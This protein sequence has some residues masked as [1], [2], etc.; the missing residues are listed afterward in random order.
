MTAQGLR[1]GLRYG[2]SGCHAPSCAEGGCLAAAH[3]RMAAEAPAGTWPC[4]V[5]PLPRHPRCCCS[6]GR[7]PG[8]QRH[9]AL[10]NTEWRRPQHLENASRVGMPGLLATQ[11]C[12][13]PDAPASSSAGRAPTLQDAFRRFAKEHKVR[14]GEQQT[15]PSL[16]VWVS[17]T[18]QPCTPAPP[19]TGVPRDVPALACG[20]VPTGHG[21][22]SCYAAAA[23]IQEFREPDS[24]LCCLATPLECILPLAS[25]RASAKSSRA[26]NAG[27]A[28]CGPA[29]GRDLP[30]AALRAAFLEGAR[31][32]ISESGPKCMQPHV[33][34][35]IVISYLR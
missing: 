26:C 16:E 22:W 14:G 7:W 18:L 23:H 29:G 15:R 9:A 3:C 2:C 1:Q 32:Y 5:G 31:K 17:A 12:W 25:Q 19:L 6:E 33:T 28:D 27:G 35:S 11:R 24:R 21:Q 13:A 4:H 8:I 34:R 10:H 20:R 30:T